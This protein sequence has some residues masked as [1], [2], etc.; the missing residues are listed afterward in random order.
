MIIGQ[1]NM[2]YD[3]NDVLKKTTKLL[4]RLAYY[5]RIHGLES[6]EERLLEAANHKGHLKKSD[7]FLQL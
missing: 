6:R 3:K 5:N 2:M 4:G 1:T 7:R